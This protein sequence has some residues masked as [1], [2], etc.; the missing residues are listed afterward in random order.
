MTP[1]A[2]ALDQLIS[3]IRRAFRDLA[4]L[5]DALHA[6]LGITS[7]RRSVME[8][9]AGNGPETVPGIA[10]ARGVTRQH[11]QQLADQLIADR[12]VEA[13]PNP[14]HRRSPLMALSEEGR[15]LFAAMRAREAEGLQRLAEDMTL[16]DIMTAT[17]TLSGL[18]DRVGALSDDLTTQTQEKDR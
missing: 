3:E 9:L 14:A 4:N 16:E 10:R 8:Y 11:I 13:R 5:G 1:Q 7:A 2:V 18:R 6:N 12:L 17:R 15:A